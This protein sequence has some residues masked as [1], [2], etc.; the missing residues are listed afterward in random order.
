MKQLGYQD[1]TDGRAQ[2]P[3][4]SAINLGSTNGVYVAPLASLR[5]FMHDSPHQDLLS[6][7]DSISF[8]CAA[9]S[10]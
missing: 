8:L 5:E 4:C 6:D 1:D 2:S 3:V 7:G 9:G 10:D